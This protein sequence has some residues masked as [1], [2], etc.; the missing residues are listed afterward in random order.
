MIAPK[1]VAIR[2]TYFH[3]VF[4]PTGGR[5]QPAPPSLYAGDGHHR[6]P[7]LHEGLTDCSFQQ[8]MAPHD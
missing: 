4:P 1:L 2:P 3:F 6:T 5:K 7:M 8:R